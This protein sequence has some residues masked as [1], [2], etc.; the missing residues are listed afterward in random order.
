MTSI[1][2]GHKLNKYVKKLFLRCTGLATDLALLKN[3]LFFTVQD[4]A[5]AKGSG[6][7][8]AY[9][10]CSRYVQRGYFIR[11]KRDFYVHADTWNRYGFL[12]FLKLANFLQVPSYISFTTALEYHGLT[13]QVQRNWYECVTT[14]RSN[15][16]APL[17]VTFL[18]HKLN[19]RLYFGY[20][21]IDGIFVAAPEKAVLDSAYLE[22]RGVNATDW[23]AVSFDKMDKDRM[24]EWIVPFPNQ[25]KRKIAEKCKI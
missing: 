18:Y 17:G 11:V 15:S 8:S 3:K 25:F 12:D 2:Q 21:R 16:F 4:V 19:D 14:R 6:L 1:E 23:D 9:V 13:T 20:E 24:R 10:L 22:V 7:A 5:A